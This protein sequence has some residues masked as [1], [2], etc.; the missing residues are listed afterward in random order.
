MR[1]APVLA[2]TTTWTALLAVPLVAPANVSQP[3]AL[4][5]VQLQPLSV[6]NWIV[7]VPPAALT[8]SDDRSSE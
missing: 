7:N 1:A 6:V 4:E 8:V 5:A 2:A 3:A